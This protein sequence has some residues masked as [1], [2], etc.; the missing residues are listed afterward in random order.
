MGISLKR[1]KGKNRYDKIDLMIKYARLI[2][3]CIISQ[4]LCR[5]PRFPSGEIEFTQFANGI[6][7][8]RLYRTTKIEFTYSVINIIILNVTFSFVPMEFICSVTN[9]TIPFEIFFIFQVFLFV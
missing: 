4:F 8:L 2:L 3:A 7:F 9:Q 5:L 1:S 6:R